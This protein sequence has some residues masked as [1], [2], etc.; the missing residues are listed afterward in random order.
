MKAGDLV[1]LTRKKWMFIEEYV[2]KIEK[3]TPKGY[4]KVKDMLFYPD[5]R[6][7]GKH[8]YRIEVATEEKITH[9]YEEKF[10]SEILKILKNIDEL[11]YEQAVE[12]GDLF[13]RWDYE[14]D[15]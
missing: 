7:R 12:L 8:R 14:N 4:I 15:N 3:V 10:I 13:E 9:Y 11:T 2:V 6:P 5:G 1:I